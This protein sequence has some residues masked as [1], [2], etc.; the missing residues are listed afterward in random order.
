MFQKNA[1]EEAGEQCYR[2]LEERLAAYYG[3]ALPQHPLP[4]V[5]WLQLRAQLDVARRVPVR[6]RRARWSG[7]TRLKSRQVV[8]LSLQEAFAGLLVQADYRRPQPDLRCHFNP[9]LTH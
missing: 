9:R 6:R 1:Y 3:P 5:A 8:P 7:Y 2:D 4:E